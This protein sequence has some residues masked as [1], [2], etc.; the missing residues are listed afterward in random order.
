MKMTPL[1]IAAS[2]A[3]SKT[4][5]ILEFTSA[6]IQIQSVPEEER[7]LTDEELDNADPDRKVRRMRGRELKLIQGQDILRG[8]RVIDTRWMAAWED[9]WH[10]K[11]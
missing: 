8:E 6:Q 1:A 5:S 7:N 9:F 4:F 10:S 2:H 11:E 3:L